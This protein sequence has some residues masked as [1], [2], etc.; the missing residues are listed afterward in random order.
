MRKNTIEINEL[1]LFFICLSLIYPIYYL[2]VSR[3]YLIDQ[4]PDQSC[5]D[6]V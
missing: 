3:I 6:F 4:E 1:F 2:N 5:Q